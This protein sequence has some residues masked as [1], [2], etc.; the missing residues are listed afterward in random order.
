[1]TVT[2][3]AR[4]H[5]VHRRIAPSWIDT[6]LALVTAGGLLAVYALTLAPDVLGGDAGELQFVPR[7][8][9]LA[10]PTGYPLQTLLGHVWARL[11]PWGSVAWRANL[12]SAVAGATGSALLY[13]AARGYGASRGAALLAALMLGLSEVYWDQAI[14]GDKYALTAALLAALLWALARWR[15]TGD[16]GWLLASATL[17]GLGLTQHRSLILVGPPLLALWLLGQPAILRR[18]RQAAC[19]AL[20]MVTPLLLYFWLPVGA[21]RGLPPDTWH[22]QC[23][24]DWASYLLDR[25]YLGEV[26]PLEGVIAYLAEYGRWLVSTF[27]VPGAVVGVVGSGAFM[28]RRPIDGICLLSAFF[29]LAVLSASYRVPRQWVFYLPSFV[30]FTLFISFGLTAMGEVAGR[31]LPGQISLA[32]TAL[33]FVSV[34]ALPAQGVAPRYREHWQAHTDGGTLDLWRQDLK[35]GYLARR[36]AE[37]GL[38]AVEPGATIAADWEQATALWYVQRVEGLRPDVRVVYPIARWE[39]ALRRGEPT[40]LAR[41][42]SNAGDHRLSAAGPL[43]RIGPAPSVTP[44]PDAL[45]TAVRWKEGLELVGCSLDDGDW[46]QGYVVAVTL[47]LRARDRLAADYC[48]SLRLYNDEGAQ[49]W[50]EDRRHPV[51]GMYPTSRWAPGDTV[52]DYFEVPFPH[53]VPAGRYHLGLIAYT[54]LPEGGFRNLQLEEGGEVAILPPFEVPPRP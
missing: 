47:Y 27:G 8:L 25:S 28:R 15:S 38:S 32:A 29:L 40:Y 43:V 21:A 10:H 6:A 24:T 19:L 54:A 33:V 50:A 49:V 45:P 36:L 2:S 37:N 3:P 7:I 9:S 17:Y 18:P 30:V 4:S 13:G 51:L 23:L 20:G 14:L 5:A 16:R 22:P 12:L 52:A 1:M 53:H 35:K 26:R 11:L 39:G 31:R 42:V 48:L 46:R 44:P 34:A 41:I